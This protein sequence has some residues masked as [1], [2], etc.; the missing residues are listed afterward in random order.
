MIKATYRNIQVEILNV[1]EGQNEMLSSVRAIEG[2][3]F[4]KPGKWIRKSEYATVKVG[5]LSNITPDQDPQP[6]GPNLLS[7]ALAYREKQRWY[8]GESVWLWKNGKTGAFLKETEGFINLC[9]TG[10]SKSVTV[11]W[12][13]PYSRQWEVSHDLGT[14]Y[15]QWVNGINEGAK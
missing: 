3:P 1:Y 13:N 7:L 6:L 4:T 12:L 11:F 2:K 14:N 5:E 8:A 10:Y 15:Y 9:L